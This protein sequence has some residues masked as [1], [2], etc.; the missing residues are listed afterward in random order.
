MQK[1]S[2]LKALVTFNVYDRKQM[3]A[4]VDIYFPSFLISDLQK[5]P[6]LLRKCQR[7]LPKNKEQ[8]YYSYI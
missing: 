1:L 5:S 4:V 3:A 8:Q 7:H 2:N 6:Q